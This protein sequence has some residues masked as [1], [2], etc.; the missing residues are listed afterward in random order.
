MA[1]KKMPGLKGMVYEPEPTPSEVR[2]HGCPECYCCQMC[3]DARCCL[4]LGVECRGTGSEG[5]ES[6]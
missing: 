6:E 3:S 1:W 5:Q 4:C 2:K